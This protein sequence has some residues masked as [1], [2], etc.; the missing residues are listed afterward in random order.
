MTTTFIAAVAIKSTV[1]LAILF[2][3]A[4]VLRRAPAAVRHLLWSVGLVGLM[5]LPFLP[6]LVPWRI[7]ILPAAAV[8]ENP[9]V[10]DEAG[11]TQPSEGSELKPVEAESGRVA[12]GS[13]P[14]SATRAGRFDPWG[15]ITKP[16]TIALVWI[17]GALAV[18]GWL[19]AGYV[20]IWRVRRRASLL[21]GPPWEELARVASERMGVATPVR[22]LMSRRAPVP[23]GAGIFRPAVVFPSSAEGWSAQRRQAVLLHEIA[24]LQRGDAMPQVIA[25]LVCAVFWFQ[26]LVWVASRRLRSESERSCDDLVLRSGTR[27]SQYVDDLIEIVRGSQRSWALAVAHPVARRSEF[28]GRVLAILEPGIQ[29]H[30]LT[31][32]AALSV[33]L[34]VALSAMPLAAMGRASAES[35]LGQPDADRESFAGRDESGVPPLVGAEREVGVERARSQPAGDPAAGSSLQ[36]A[37]A[38][39]ASRDLAGGE[40]V[41]PSPQESR[42]ESQ[43]SVASHVAA[44]VAALGDEDAE[45]RRSVATSLGSL[46][47]TAAVLALMQAVREDSDAG[48]RAA[49]AWAL[50]EIGDA[51]AVP[52]LAE[53]LR[54]DQVIEVRKAAAW[55][56]GEI[57]DPR[58]VE[59]L[60]AAIDDTNRDVRLA[61]I[62]ALGELE[63]PAS[64]D[65]LTTALRAD[66]AEI[67]DQAAWALGEIEDAKAVPA[68]GAVLRSDADPVVRAKAA[69]ALGEIGDAGAVGALSAALADRDVEVRRMAVW[70]LGEIEEPSAV[71][72][73]TGVLQDSDVEI[74][75]QAVHAL[76]QIESPDAVDPLLEAL[77]DSDAEVRELAA[78]SLGQIEDPRAAPGLTAALA[79]PEVKVR[80]AAGGA[81]ADLELRSAPPAL[82]AA[83]R[84]EDIELR[85]TAAYALGEIG[86]PA[87]VPGLTE[88]A[89]T[90]DIETRRAAINALAEIHDP[91]AYQVLVEALKDADPEIRRAA[92]QALGEGRN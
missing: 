13:A 66:D 37:G 68:L 65:A 25:H 7:G 23:F 47:D 56:L 82:I 48:V 40:V 17:A 6:A 78:W 26:P 59:P 92:A 31:P 69:W 33:I 84:D 18:L 73:L 39:L 51:R 57:D 45:V 60:G 35:A 27:P 74:R 2:L 79:D 62:T 86:D 32:T 55:A 41:V 9:I 63:S 14:A 72:S 76:G 53:A 71:G 52:A 90:A 70:G 85:R 8:V 36:D 80:R 43:A 30:G 75:R 34:A 20:T 83:L 87:A 42:R 1:Y 44:L 16:E 77:R 64:V 91:A 3:I 15:L 88:L 50:G 22:L 10:G 29:R 81:L 21:N 24:H 67:R 54:R 61:V 19:V 89:R 12:G 38:N 46:Q 49:A 11:T 5:A 4:V 58:A 28:E